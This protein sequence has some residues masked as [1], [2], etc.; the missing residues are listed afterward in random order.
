MSYAE[1][2]LMAIGFAILAFLIFFLIIIVLVFLKN[3][4]S[5]KKEIEEKVKTNKY[6]NL[7]KK[8]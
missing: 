7:L 5:E 2:D 8:D 1:Q 3:L 4:F 6:E